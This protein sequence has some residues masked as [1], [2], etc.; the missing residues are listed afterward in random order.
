MVDMVEVVVLVLVVLVVLM[1]VLEMHTSI[2]AG[3][4]LFLLLRRAVS[5]SW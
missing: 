3:S 4:W 1:L 5:W 2:P